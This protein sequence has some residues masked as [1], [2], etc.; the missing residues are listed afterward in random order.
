[1]N[2][3][4]TD[5]DRCPVVDIGLALARV[6]HRLYPEQLGLDKMD[7][8]LGHRATLE[9]IKQD[10]PLAEIKAL[11]AE[12]RAQFEKRRETFLLYH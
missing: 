6:L 9:A 11:W 12:D 8:L 1:V 10:R 4:L 2:I 5:R 3:L 7:K